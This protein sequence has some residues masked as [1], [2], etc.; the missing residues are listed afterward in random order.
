MLALAPWPDLK[1]LE[2]AD[3]EAEVGWVVDV[4]SQVRSARAEMNVPAGALVPL[5][6]VGA[7]EAE[8][9]RAERWND[10]LK[11]LA[12]LSWIYRV[13]KAPPQ[14]VQ[15]LVRGASLALPLEGVI[16]FAVERAR[17]EKGM[18]QEQKE[19]GKIDAKLGNAD[20]L[21]RAPEEVVE[22]NQERRDQA[23]ARLEKM[24]AALKM[25]G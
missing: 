12:R 6:L 3:A 18:A 4:I 9:D 24:A 20:F 11:R 23:V 8:A 7:G 22:E 10:V 14:S 5:A 21:R 13:E 19:I 16:D 2:N 17:L 1:G 15:I 25:L